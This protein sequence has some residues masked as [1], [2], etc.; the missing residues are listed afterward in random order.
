M[1]FEILSWNAYFIWWNNREKNPQ[2]DSV[3]KMS[4]KSYRNLKIILKELHRDQKALGY[5]LTFKI[6]T[7]M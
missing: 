6:L 4:N 5:K 7:Y 1:L 3:T 2:K